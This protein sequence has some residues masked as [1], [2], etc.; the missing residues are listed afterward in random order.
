MLKILCEI[1]IYSFYSNNVYA[2]LLTLIDEMVTDYI[3][4]FKLLY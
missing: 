3:T 2:I 4:T 1:E